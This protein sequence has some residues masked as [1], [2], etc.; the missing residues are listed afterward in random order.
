MPSNKE[1]LFQDH[2][3]QF[4][5]NEHQFHALDK[6]E[7]PPQD[8]HIIALHL[9][10]FIKT[11]QAEAYDQLAENY[12]SDS[13]NEI[14]KALE[15]RLSRQ[16][17]LW[18][19]MRDGLEVK[20]V[21]FE[22]YKP[23]SRSDTS[24]EQLK[25]YQANHFSFK[26]EYYYNSQSKERID[27]V[28]WLNGL[29]IIVLELKHEDEGQTVDDAIDESFLKRDLNNRLFQLPFLYVAA[30]NLEVKVATNPS[31]YKNFRWFNAQ[32]FNKAETQGE[33]P[34]EH[35]YRH[36]L[37]KENIA[38]YLEYFLVQVPA[39]EDISS[40]GELISKPAFTIFPRYHQLR[41][42]QNLS[43][44]VRH[45]VNQTGELGLKYLIN[46]S[47][48]SGK[49][50]TIAWMAD[51]L[52][53]LYDDD[54][55]KVFD[56]IVILTDRRSLDKNVCDDLENF[57]HL[58]G[59]IK[60][61]KK[62]RQLAEH[63]NKN[64]DIIVTTIHKFDY[65]QEHLES[66]EG[67]KE[68]K[69]AFL[70]DEAHRSQEGKMAL[71]M[72]QFFTDDGEAYEVEED[73][74]Q[75]SDEIATE[76]EKLDISNQVFVAFTATTTPKTVAYFGKPFDTYSEAEAIEEGYILDVAQ[77]I[78][79]YERPCITYGLKQR[80]LIRNIPQVS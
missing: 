63:L 33:Y 68:R 18:R 29:P 7:L 16:I 20:G 35:L 79:S 42:S 38:K 70:I 62:S 19:I 15:K 57:T 30:S 22:L 10:D 14:L 55:N 24:P 73:E 52:D 54:N 32:L 9:T 17:P 67:L 5:E 74:S 11:T 51:L 39:K 37:S 8:N 46:H 61:A 3:C 56:N 34:V 48:G 43:E 45:K 59:K 75:S 71:T 26:K 21:K 58:S 65:I 80:F 4:L 72:R 23:K 27:L 31:D 60:F 44:D 13:D 78:I 50:L 77:N 41:A 1:T 36:A 28:I 47:A 12:H 6:S 69:I 49:T 25:N 64:R 2:I 53:S 40:D 76:L 66:V